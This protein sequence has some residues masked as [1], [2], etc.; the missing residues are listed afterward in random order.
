[1]QINRNSRDYNWQLTS[2][3]RVCHLL[4][5]NTC[6]KLI[7]RKACDNQEKSDDLGSEAGRYERNIWNLSKIQRFAC[8]LCFICWES[9]VS[10]H[11]FTDFGVGPHCRGQSKRQSV[12]LIQ[13]YTWRYLMV[14]THIYF[15]LGRTY[16]SGYSECKSCFN[17]DKRR[18]D[19][20]KMILKLCSSLY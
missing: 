19:T 17:M 11:R 2:H 12:Q 1:M 10:S 9:S 4:I 5:K 6:T 20:P 16:K 13:R 3:R 7:Y 14:I 15:L 18:R 8:A